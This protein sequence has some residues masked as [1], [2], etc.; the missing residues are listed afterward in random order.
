MGA[1]SW[2][3]LAQHCP[4]TSGLGIYKGVIWVIV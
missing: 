1:L 3:F 2:V 4:E